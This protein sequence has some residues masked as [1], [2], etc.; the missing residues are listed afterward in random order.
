MNIWKMPK[1]LNF[2]NLNPE[3][4]NLVI[5]IVMFKR[6]TNQNAKYANVKINELLK[7]SC[8]V[9]YS[10]VFAMLGDALTHKKLSSHGKVYFANRFLNLLTQLDEVRES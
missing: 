7:Q 2:E 9:K 3:D 6:K 4:K 1:V 10:F 5:E 8:A